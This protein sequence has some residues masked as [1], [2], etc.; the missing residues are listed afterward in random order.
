MR[1]RDRGPRGPRPG[2]IRIM[3]EPLL[4]GTRKIGEGNPVFIV[5]ELSANHGGEYERAVELVHAA[6]DAGADAVK[7]QTYTP[8]TMTIESD[9]EAFRAG[10]GT[11]WEGRT[12]YDLYSE[13]QTPWSWQPRL[14]EVAGHLGIEL[15]SSPFDETAVDFL[16]EIGVPAF[17]IASFEIV[18]IPLIRRAAA[19]G[20]PLILSTGMASLTE[21]SDAVGAA[22]EAGASGVALLKCT[23]A[24]PAPPEEMNL[25]T[26][27]DLRERFGVPV[28]LSD[29]TLGSAVAVAAVSLGASIVEKHLTI[30]RASGGPDAAFS[31]EPGEFKEMVRE[32]RIVEAA[33]GEIRYGAVRAEEPS[34]IFRRSLFVVETMKP[35]DLFNRRNVRA[36]RPGGGLPPI[37]L[38]KV[39]GRKA[40]TRI[41]RGVP[42]SWDLID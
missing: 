36:I 20:K 40:R 35:G 23:S 26:I 9:R 31:M 27:P 30:S 17:K 7:L 1:E 37:D 34:R 21:I 33:L 28:G 19:T 15:F 25:R 24:Y 5:A 4:I 11:M 18:D 38:E 2:R 13:A 42:L 22:R 39:L 12:L 14:R 3:I 8:D 16:H 32:V 41:E 10:P 6:H 29:H